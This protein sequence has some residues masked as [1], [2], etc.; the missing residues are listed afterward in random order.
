VPDN[1]KVKLDFK[2]IT[3]VKL[4]NSKRVYTLANK[5]TD[6]TPNNRKGL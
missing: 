4:S 2:K 3:I 5:L 1:A 6:I